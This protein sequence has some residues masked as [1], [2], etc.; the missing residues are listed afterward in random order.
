MNCEKCNS[1]MILIIQD[2]TEFFIN[3]EELSINIE[4][5]LCA[6]CKNEFISN[7]QLMKNLYAM[8]EFEDKRHADNN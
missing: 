2:T 5:S 4:S 7:E 1:D 6:E 3:G 8:F